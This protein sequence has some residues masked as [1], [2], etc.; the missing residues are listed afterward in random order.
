MTHVTQLHHRRL[1]HMARSGAS[2]DRRQFRRYEGAG[3]IANIDQELLEVD[4]ISVSGLRVP[5]ER[6]PRGRTVQVQ[7]IPREG[8]K[9][10]LN[11]AVNTLAEVVGVGN[12]HTRL[13]FVSL[14]FSLAKLVIRHIATR[15]GVQPFMVK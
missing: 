1:A 2:D 4:D 12:G 3:L 14:Q 15:T 9:L 10:A 11:H 8:S 7:L 13:H 5:G 6:L